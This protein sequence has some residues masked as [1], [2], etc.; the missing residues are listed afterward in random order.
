MNHNTQPNNS[1]ASRR[2][3]TLAQAAHQAKNQGAN[4]QALKE[5]LQKQ[6]YNVKEIETLFLEPKAKPEAATAKP[7]IV[8]QDVSKNY[9]KFAALKKINLKIPEGQI[10]ALLGPNGAG[11]TTL[12]Q[13][14]ATLQHA[15]QGKVFIVGLDTEKQAQKLRSLIGLAGQYAA[16]DEKLTGQENLEI[17]ARLYHLSKKEARRR[18]QDLLKQFDLTYA[19]KR[20]L[21]NYSGGM[22]R[23]LDLA[24]SLIIKPKV[25]FLD[26]PTT[27]LDPRSRFAMWSV[28]RELAAE[29]TTVLLTTQYLEEADQLADQIFVMDKGQIISQGTAHELKK[30]AGGEILEVHFEDLGKIEQAAEIIQKL[31]KQKPNINN[32][33]GIITAP[34]SQGASALVEAVRLLDQANLKIIDIMLRRPT[35]DDVFLKLTS[36]TPEK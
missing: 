29:K 1:K 20:V 15:T 31:T 21:K 23:R 27:G 22:R 30:Q 18:T 14:M 12:V 4:G 25:L 32:A 19:A 35:L 11:K 9:G 5:K 24:A 3:S 8:V 36:H 7:I 13:I 28:I 26:E 34:L 17:F 33:S 10:T 16:V 2:K 6:G